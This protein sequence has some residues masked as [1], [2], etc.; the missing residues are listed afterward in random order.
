M[1]NLDMSLDV[2]NILKLFLHVQ[3]FAKCMVHDFLPGLPTYPN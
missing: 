2:L 3:N 1:I